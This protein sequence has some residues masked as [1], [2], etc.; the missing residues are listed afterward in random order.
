MSRLTLGGVFGRR[1][2]LGAG[3]LK[4][5][6]TDATGAPAGRWVNIY[7]QASSSFL[8]EGPRTHIDRIKADELTGEWVLD[9]LDTGRLYTVIA[10]DPDQKY[11]PVI[12][13]NLRPEPME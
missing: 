13:T 7:T 9:Y 6:V 3:R 12:K 10:H 5:L 4:G 1:G 2:G 11:D 8:G